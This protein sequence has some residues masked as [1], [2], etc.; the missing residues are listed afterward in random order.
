MEGVFSNKNIL[1]I[2]T[3]WWKHLIAITFLG[4]VIIGASTY[5]IKPKYKSY[6]VVYPV[7]LGAYSEESYTEQMVAILNSR[8]VANSVITEF[9]LDNH[10]RISKEDKTYNSKLYEYY[11][12]LVSIRKTPYESVEISVLDTDPKLACEIVNSILKHYNNKV[13]EIHKLKMLE[14]VNVNR[15]LVS[16]FEEQVGHSNK[17]LETI[18]TRSGNKELS[19]IMNLT[20]GDSRIENDEIV[21]RTKDSDEELDLIKGYGTEFLR[22]F[23]V[24][25]EQASA[26]AS[27][28]IEMDQ[29]IIEANKEI[30]YYTMVSSPYAPDKKYSPMR[31]PIALIGGLSVLV[32]SFMVLGFIERKNINA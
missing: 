5:L 18:I 27:I 12:D 3:K 25:R 4:T 8:D 28:K 19:K 15:Q 26:M 13:R 2:F 29:Q 11:Y 16:M 1:Y 23:K 20:K 9:G 31:V 14:Y 32:L 17:I 7:N 10:W 24:Y 22:Y 30:T 6:A 21:L